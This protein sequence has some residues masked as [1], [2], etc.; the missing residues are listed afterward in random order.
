MLVVEHDEAMMRAADTLIDIGP[1]AGRGG[2]RIVAQGTPAEVIADP[3]FD[4]RPLSVRPS[5]RFRF[6]PS[7]RRD[8]QN[9]L[10][11][12]G[13]GHDEQS[14][15][16]RSPHSRWAC[17]VCVTGVSGSGKSS[18]VNET[19]ARALAR[20]LG[21]VAAKPGPHRSL[22]GAS[23]I[24]K[25]VEIDQSPIGRTPRSNPATY[26]GVFDEI[27]KVFADTREAR[28]RGY[29]TGRFSFN[30]EGGPLRGMPRAGGAADRDEFSAR[31]V[32]RLARSA[33][34]S[35]STGKRS[36]FTIATARSPTCSTCGST[37][38]RSSSRIF[39]SSSGC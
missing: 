2:G 33:T 8:D 9:P 5:W 30:T 36:K 32:R 37:K 4:H 11:H 16:R 26:T 38:P 15:G 14:Q 6:P 35:D 10:D 12:A 39:R 3:R 7:R 27:R 23:N 21:Q 31:P 28:Q 29:R 13:R 18:L 17:F 1:A 19:L 34:A 22:R 20:R 24:D 25:L